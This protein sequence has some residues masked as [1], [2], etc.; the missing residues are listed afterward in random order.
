MYLSCD[1]GFVYADTNYIGIYERWFDR[2]S[3]KYLG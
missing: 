2:Y 3:H 1:N